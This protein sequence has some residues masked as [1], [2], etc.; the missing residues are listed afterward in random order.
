VFSFST[1]TQ[2]WGISIAAVIGAFVP[3]LW[4]GLI[5]VLLFPA[6]QAIAR[7]LAQLSGLEIFGVK[8]ALAGGDRAMKAAIS[9]AEKHPRFDPVEVPDEARKQALERAE[10]EQHLLS[11]AEILWVDDHPSNNRNEARM[12]RA[13]GAVITF[14]SSTEEAIEALRDG[15]AQRDPFAVVVSDISR[16]T[17]LPTPGAEAAQAKTDP[18]AGLKMLD[19]FKAAGLDVPVI[20]YIGRP[21]KDKGVPGGAFGL[22][23]RPDELLQLVL[24]AL[25]RPRPVYRGAAPTRPTPRGRSRRPAGA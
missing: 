4:I 23:N 18:V 10:R 22:T 19:E 25:D 5:A 15:F 7:M 6:R 8:V 20:F 3:Y 17:I 1:T 24:D 14:A 9:M 11:G 2:G 12:L 13:F 21:E 16:D